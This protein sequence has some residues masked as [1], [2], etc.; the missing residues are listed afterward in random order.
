M[1]FGFLGLLALA[2]W[3]EARAQTGS[4]L[5]L[6]A[7]TVACT[8][9]LAAV[10][11]TPTTDR[12]LIGARF[13]DEEAAKDTIAACAALAEISDD[14]TNRLWLAYA[15][16]AA[17]DDAAAI[18]TLARIRFPPPGV[19]GQADPRVRAA[20]LRFHL[21]QGASS[22]SNLSAAAP[23]SA[24]F[25]DQALA[26]NRLIT[27]GQAGLIAPEEVIKA[28]ET[29][30]DFSSLIEIYTGIQT[31]DPAG[32]PLGPDLAALRATADLAAAH[33]DPLVSLMAQK[34]AAAY[35]D[36]GFDRQNLTADPAA[37]QVRRN[38]GLLTGLAAWFDISQPEEYR[39][40]LAAQT[41]PLVSQVLEE[42]QSLT[43]IEAAGEAVA[44]D[45]AGV[46]SVQGLIPRNTDSLALDLVSPLAQARTLLGRAR[47]GQLDPAAA[48]A[49]LAALAEQ[50]AC[51]FDLWAQHSYLG[52]LPTEG[53]GSLVDQVLVLYGQGQAAG[54][55]G[56]FVGAGEL[57]R[58]GQVGGV[59][60]FAEAQRLFTRALEQG[61]EG[62]C[63]RGDRATAHVNLA[64][65]AF[66]GQGTRQDLG[67]AR[68]HFLAAARLGNFAAAEVLAQLYAFGLGV[69]R[70]PVLAHE[71]ASKAFLW[72]SVE[73]Q[74][75]LALSL[76]KDRGIDLP[77]LSAK[78]PPDLR[79][80][81]KEEALQLLAAATTLAETFQGNFYLAL[82]ALDDPTV[83]TR[84]GLLKEAGELFATLGGAIGDFERGYAAQGAT[85]TE[86]FDRMRA[87]LDAIANLTFTAARY[88]VDGGWPHD[89]KRALAFYQALGQTNPAARRLLALDRTPYLTAN[90]RVLMGPGPHTL[91]DV[92]ALDLSDE[93]VPLPFHM[94]LSP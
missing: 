70:D 1:R 56:A 23:F 73:N 47:A 84:H 42:S 28:L 14:A 60:D 53:A 59:Y 85:R 20:A 83:L 7:Q 58:W 24:L 39:D 69:P 43:A 38:Q 92:V 49:S 41:L 11:A 3:G 18:K 51:V 9:N 81:P 44:L 17:N 89:P 93:L 72:N 31:L 33:A 6:V 71:F 15:Q 87:E 77:G 12:R 90:G 40:A 25:V 57:Y 5:E 36:R 65:L 19:Y 55:T 22:A 45:W 2:L 74:T 62:D 27:L 88:D 76:F 46:Q 86:Y 91:A 35:Y 64:W 29:Q 63:G 30:G 54:K 80:A 94:L 48:R 34:Q 79:L 13:L 78:G 21:L 8:S 4:D 32:T 26:P 75:F 16:L 37:A 82:A 61:P 66:N 68:H 52:D 50:D 67:V 10:Y